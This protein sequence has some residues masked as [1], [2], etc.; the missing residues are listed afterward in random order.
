MYVFY[1]Y[2]IYI[3]V[4]TSLQTN[5]FQVTVNLINQFVGRGPTLDSF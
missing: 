4:Y 3:H 1:I 5:M 2:I